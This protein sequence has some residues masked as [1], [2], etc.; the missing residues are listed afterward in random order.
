MC[1]SPI[2]SSFNDL[3][4]P[5]LFYVFENTTD[6]VGIATV[7]VYGLACKD[8]LYPAKSARA[9]HFWPWV[10]CH[11]V[12]FACG[13]SRFLCLPRAKPVWR[14]QASAAGRHRHHPPLAKPPQHIT[15]APP[16]LGRVGWPP[17]SSISSTSMSSQSSES[18]REAAWA[19]RNVQN[20]PDSC[21]AWE[22]GLE[23]DSCCYLG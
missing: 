22:N 6:T 5:K 10:P 18:L 3:I 7:L 2:A 17:Q 16:A 9:Q 20:A 8:L 21:G 11:R 12:H 23:R 13:Q 4:S 19:L 14:V 15:G 1:E